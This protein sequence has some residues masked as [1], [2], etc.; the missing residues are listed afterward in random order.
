MKNT[1]KAFIVMFPINAIS[2]DLDYFPGPKH[3]VDGENVF[4]DA[5]K[6]AF[7]V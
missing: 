6:I 1:D 2:A 7:N 4:V 3:F 5:G